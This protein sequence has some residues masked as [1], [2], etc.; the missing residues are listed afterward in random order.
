MCL[1]KVTNNH[2]ICYSY[3]S[4]DYQPMTTKSTN[5]NF[6]FDSGHYNQDKSII[7]SKTIT[8]PSPS[9][10]VRL[11]SSKRN[12]ESLLSSQVRMRKRE[13]SLSNDHD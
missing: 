7:S 12:N 1:S 11:V 5:D 3:Y 10:L 2:S 4:L 6:L 9:S 13:S 8:T